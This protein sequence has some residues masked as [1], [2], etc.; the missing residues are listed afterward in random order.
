MF[1]AD[2]RMKGFPIGRLRSDGAVGVGRTPERTGLAAQPLAIGLPAQAMGDRG[3]RV[4]RIG[5]PP[6]G[7]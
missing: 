5:N 2:S 6:V 1:S 4:G 3:A 7:S